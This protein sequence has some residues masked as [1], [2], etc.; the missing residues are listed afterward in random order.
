MTD[1]VN[2]TGPNPRLTIRFAVVGLGALGG[3]WHSILAAQLRAE[4]ECQRDRAQRN[5]LEAAGLP[6][7]VVGQFTTEMA[8]AVYGVVLAGQ[9]EPP[10]FTS[11][12]TMLSLVPPTPYSRPKIERYSGAVIPPRTLSRRAVRATLAG[13][14]RQSVSGPRWPGRRYGKY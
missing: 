2:T 12:S 5:R 6:A 13:A 7:S 8:S 9:W 3:P 14:V 10:D 1:D 4:E 11:L